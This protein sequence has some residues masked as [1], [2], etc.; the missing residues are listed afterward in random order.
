MGTIT[1]KKSEPELEQTL[2]NPDQL[3]SLLMAQNNEAGNQ[4]DLDQ[5]KEIMTRDSPPI[6]QVIQK[7]ALSNFNNQMMISPQKDNFSSANADEELAP[8]L[9]DFQNEQPLE[10]ADPGLVDPV[11][12]C[13][14][15]DYTGRYVYLR[16]CIG[17]EE[18]TKGIV[19]G[20][21]KPSTNKKDIPKNVNIYL[22]DPRLDSRH[23]H[24]FCRKLGYLNQ[25]VVRDI[26]DHSKSNSG[27]WMQMESKEVDLFTHDYFDREFSVLNCKYKFRFEKL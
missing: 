1:E 12:K 3:N 20:G 15:G 16:N 26:S 24:V 4:G 8:M 6:Q 27:V 22:E 5:I 17:D 13:I 21:G 14:Q 9:A 7:T 23:I 2:L 18:K 11:L 25:F 10:E 19:I